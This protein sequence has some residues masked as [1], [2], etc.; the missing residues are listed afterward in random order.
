MTATF[1]QPT[2]LRIGIIIESF[3]QP[4]WVRKS[5]ENVLATGRGQFALVVKVPDKRDSGGLLYKLYNRMDRRLYPTT[6]T[7]LV[8]IEDL[9]SKLPVV[10]DLEKVA[11][12]D[13][14]LLMNFASTG[15]NQKVSNSAKHG[16]WFH[17]FGDAPGFSELLHDMPLTNL[18]LKS[19]KG[20]TEQIIY[21]SGS[22]M[23]SKFSVA[24]NNNT[25][26]WKAAAFMA[27][28]LRDLQAGGN[29]VVKFDHRLN[30]PGT[31]GNA[32]MS[33]IF[34][35]L[36]GRAAARVFEKF[37][38]FDQWI[39]GYR[40]DNDEFKYLLPPADR[41]W[42]DPFQVK[43]DGRYYIFFED[44]VNSAGRAHISVVEVDRNGIISG[45]TE[46]LKL[47]CHL[48]Y[49]FIFE[50]QG[51]Y[52]MIP[53]TGERN[54]VELYRATSFPF[55]WEPV[56]VLLE[57][58]A[59]LDT[60]L[61]EVNGT[62][63]MF[64]NIEEEGVAVNWDELHLYL[65]DSPLGPWKPHARNPI[66]SD[67]RLARPAGRLFWLNGA[68]FRPS[69]DSSHRYGYGTI[70]NIVTE[71]S[72]TAYKE[73]PVIQFKPDLDND[74]LGIHTVNLLE[75][76]TVFDCLMKRS[77]FGKVQPPRLKGSLDRLSSDNIKAALKDRTAWAE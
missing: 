24:V 46:V 60:T 5:L 38:S 20:E 39:V 67:V 19:L 71:I 34:L 36:A 53:E 40:F 54:V 64:V 72:P 1:A 55:K 30:K 74:L 45:P 52:Y 33:Q 59:P 70:I 3:S 49:P 8:N 26:Y 21:F 65:A 37:S 18:S 32:A 51:D 77:K 63:M 62:W 7:E 13:L 15:W 22:P 23:L 58:R 29:E 25:C 6:A 76:L 27:R 43:V 56:K 10:E 12:F 44:Y 50:W 48:S 41:F 68:L 66:V 42:A 9:F 2:L 35:K 75:E 14:D 57:A 16:V 73:T 4:R 11:E 17:T 28:A 69:Q 47:D 61:I 31:P